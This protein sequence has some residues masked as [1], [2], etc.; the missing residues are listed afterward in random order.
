MAK[1]FK[2]KDGFTTIPFGFGW[3]IQVLGCEKGAM[4]RMQKFDIRAKK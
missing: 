2:R 4:K 1:K 3:G